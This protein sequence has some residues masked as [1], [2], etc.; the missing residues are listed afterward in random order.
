[1]HSDL[2]RTEI[3][4]G[5]TQVLEEWGYSRVKHTDPSW[6]ESSSRVFED[7]FGIVALFAYDR[8]D[9]LLQAW[10]KAQGLLVDLISKFLRH[11]QPKAWDGYLV[12]LTPDVVPT[13][14]R[15][16]LETIRYNTSRVRK[17]VAAGDTLQVLADLREVLLALSPLIPSV[18]QL[19]IQGPL[20]LLPKLLETH[21]IPRELSSEVVAAYRRNTPLFDA[22]HSYAQRELT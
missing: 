21:G 7:R 9:E 11:D 8:W 1:M 15:P 22:L 2:T 17:I 4:A 13:S 3:I 20:E 12:L 19:E 10:P 16:A 6:P 5:A 14:D 18:A